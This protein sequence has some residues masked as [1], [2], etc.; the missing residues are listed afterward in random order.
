MC[1]ILRIY[2]GNEYVGSLRT[3]AEASKRFGHNGLRFKY[4]HAVKVNRQA[5]HCLCQI[6]IEHLLATSGYRALRRGDPRWDS[7]DIAIE[8]TEVRA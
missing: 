2:H 5:E 1:T 6:D 3:I 8:R 4:D 7:C